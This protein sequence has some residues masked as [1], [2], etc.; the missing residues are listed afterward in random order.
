H[1]LLAIGSLQ[2][3]LH[4]HG[5]VP[6]GALAVR[7]ARDQRR[8]LRRKGGNL[9]ELRLALY[10]ASTHTDA[11]IRERDLTS[12]CYL[13]HLGLPRPD[14]KIRR[15]A[16]WLGVVWAVWLPRADGA[17]VAI[18]EASGLSALYRAD[19][20]LV[21]DAFPSAIADRSATAILRLAT[22]GSLRQGE[23]A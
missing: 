7:R 14:G 18:T 16:V 11:S 8:A 15:F 1:S 23:A 6:P 3:V 17:W 13:R 10:G 19:A 22:R 12:E 4:R 5:T 21:R 20:R 9:E 2:V